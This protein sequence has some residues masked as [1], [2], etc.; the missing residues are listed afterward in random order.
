M[1]KLLM[2][3]SAIALLPATANAQ[4]LGAGGGGSLGGSIGGVTSG[5]TSSASSMVSRGGA[6]SRI[7]TRQTVRAPEAPAVPSNIDATGNATAGL[8]SAA[9]SV[10][11]AANASA[12]T[13]SQS[14]SG[15][16]VANGGLAPI[17]VDQ[18]AGEAAVA[19]VAPPQG[20]VFV[21]ARS[22]VIVG[23]PLGNVAARRTVFVSNGIAPISRQYVNTYVDTQFRT[24]QQD[25][26][27]TGANVERRGDQIVID[28]PSDVTFAF[29]KSDIRPR[30]YG[31]LNALGGTLSEFP[32]TY[33]DIIGHTDS[34]GTD[35]YN[36]ALP[37]AGLRSSLHPMRN[38]QW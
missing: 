33:V 28:M 15:A 22:N 4:L 12:G 30:F 19:T 8:T 29:D 13:G 36:M 23:A 17:A 31:V 5:T 26:A 20:A 7:S 27:G 32:A 37:T 38:K 21:P 34:K 3:I 1:K 24:I 25:L 18:L 16:A 14:L 10:S 9:G 2:T 35:Q 6:S 11:S